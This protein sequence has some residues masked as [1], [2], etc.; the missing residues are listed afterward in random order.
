M[1]IGPSTFDAA[2]LLGTDEPTATAILAQV[3]DKGQHQ[4]S[5]TPESGIETKTYSDCRYVN[6]KG[7]GISVRLKPPSE[8]LVDVVFL[9]SDGV[10]G[11]ASYRAG[12]LPEGLQWSHRSRDVVNRLGE[13]SD[14]FGGGRFLEVG[15]GYETKG[16]EIHFK[17]RSWDDAK[18]EIA[19]L[20]IF[21]NQEQMYDLC[22]FCAKQAKFN[23]GRCRRIRYCS[24]A[25]QRADWQRH[26]P[27]CM[28]KELP[29]LQDKNDDGPAVLGRPD[30]VLLSAMD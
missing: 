12:P 30:E 25:C 19:F 27:E 26:G 3:L 4:P 22:F 17:G 14:K 13:P 6:A 5:Q 24:S 18:N 28:A 10:D 7:A 29:L 23:C 2:V 8:G 11:F 1:S 15:I 9:Y 16:L 20:S 21:P